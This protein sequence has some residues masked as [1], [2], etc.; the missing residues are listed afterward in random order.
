MRDD[1]LLALVLSGLN[2]E[3]V[4]VEACFDTMMPYNYPSSIEEDQ[5]GLENCR[6]N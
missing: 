1:E 2:P 4:A 3:N 6:D 5:M